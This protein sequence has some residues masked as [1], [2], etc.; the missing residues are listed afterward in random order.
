[1]RVRVAVVGAGID[2]THPEIHEAL[3]D[4]RI[5]D[6]HGFPERLDP[7]QDFEGMGT[8]CVSVILR[9]MPWVSIYLARVV[10]AGGRLVKEGKYS[11][12]VQVRQIS[13]NRAYVTLGLGI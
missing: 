11:A 3:E 12:I 2:Y 10:D 1:V 13:R 8:Y 7:T 6:C 5:V 4:G 9:T